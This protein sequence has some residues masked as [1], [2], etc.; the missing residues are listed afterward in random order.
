MSLA[1][2]LDCRAAVRT[3]TATADVPKLGLD[4]HGATVING[5][6]GPP[7]TPRN[8]GG[9]SP[10]RQALAQHIEQLEKLAA[11]LETKQKPCRWL[12]EKL[13]AAT[14]ELG[15]AEAALAAV[16]AA[17]AAALAQAARSAG[18]AT[19]APVSPPSAGAGGAEE[20]AVHRARRD[21]NSV[22]MA[23][24]EVR[25][26]EARAA[27]AFEQ[28]KARGAELELQVFVELHH[29]LLKIWAD[30]HEKEV[31]AEQRL[32]SLH[33]AVGEHGRALEAK[34]PGSGLV[35][36]RALEK[37]RTPPPGAAPARELTPRDIMN[38][39]AQYASMVE[40]L[41]TDAG[42]TL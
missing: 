16:D 35:W 27:A 34:T 38:G 7:P 36:L 29:E 9:L 11:D 13:S 23:L 41:K 19:P 3:A 31:V 1:S 2:H 30:A 32:L 14:A 6:A 20:A 10:A 40:R 28:A 26:D 8:H 4:A 5:R 39:A 25:Q 15:R 17:H 33:E 24:N 37:M 12:Q 22:S 18:A 42:A 21:C